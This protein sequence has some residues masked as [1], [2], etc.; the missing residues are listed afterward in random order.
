[1]L[2]SLSFDSLGITS[3]GMIRRTQGWRPGSFCDPGVLPLSRMTDH[4]H[5]QPARCCSEDK[6][7]PFTACRDVSRTYRAHP[8]LHQ[9]LATATS[10]AKEAR[11]GPPPWQPRA[12]LAVVS[13][14]KEQGPGHFTGRA[15]I[16]IRHTPRPLL[17]LVD[18]I[19]LRNYLNL[20]REGTSELQ[21]TPDVS[22]CYIN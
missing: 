1:M 19:R 3:P 22:P 10:S 7:G 14:E 8:G 20:V 9:R 11:M 17:F 21:A 2:I 15:R 13:G 6:G 12:Q 5:I 16:S 4:V 18:F